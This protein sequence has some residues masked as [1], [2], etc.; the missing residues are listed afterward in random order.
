[1]TPVSPIIVPLLE[2]FIEFTQ[3]FEFTEI[4]EGEG[5]DR[6][7]RR[8]LFTIRKD[9]NRCLDSSL[10]TA[11]V[12]AAFKRHSPN[13][14][15]TAPSLLRSAF[16][17]ALRESTNDPEILESAA[18]AQKHSIAMQSSDTY[19]LATHTR[20]LSKAMEWCQSYAAGPV[21]PALAEEELDTDSNICQQMHA[22]PKQTD[23]AQIGIDATPIDAE[24]TPT[25][26]TDDPLDFEFDPID[27]FPTASLWGDRSFPL[28]SKLANTTTV[29][30]TDLF[31]GED[32]PSALPTEPQELGEDF[33]VRLVT[34]G[35][36]VGGVQRHRILWEQSP[37]L[38]D[39]WGGLP[40]DFVFQ[41][42]KY[43]PREIQI[44]TGRSRKDIELG[45]I[46]SIQPTLRSHAEI[47]MADGSTTQLD[48]MTSQFRRMNADQPK[49][50]KWEMTRSNTWLLEDSEWPKIINDSSCDFNFSAESQTARL[51]WMKL[52]GKSFPTVDEAI[53]VLESARS[54]IDDAECTC[55][56]TEPVL[57]WY[58]SKEPALLPTAI[59]NLIKLLATYQKGSLLHDSAQVLL[60]MCRENA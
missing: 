21:E 43:V 51:E 4:G 17:T 28:P 13:H 30:A 34:A 40:N 27:A 38:L 3:S 49:V 6:T 57:E 11:R 19:D 39:W 5:A 59:E 22:P 60:T 18:V 1:M 46:G 55:R 9:P 36:I 25:Q 29:V 48:L 35:E 10:W 16:I 53:S 2:Q 41:S 31:G 20:V 15:A 14:T 12:K 50:V 52:F 32:I 56:F 7:S 24:T 54:T 23:E 37:D 42:A 45:L 47:S 44:Q 26:L 58:L 8:Y 33:V